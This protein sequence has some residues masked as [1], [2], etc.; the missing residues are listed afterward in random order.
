MNT[1]NYRIT[2]SIP[3]PIIRVDVNY[4]LGD[5][6]VLKADIDALPRIVVGYVISGK[7]VLYTLAYQS[8][9]SNHYEFEIETENF[10][11]NLNDN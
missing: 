8:M 9:T 7:N 5:I 11:F 4:D 10:P 3:M 2:K 6:V 1:L